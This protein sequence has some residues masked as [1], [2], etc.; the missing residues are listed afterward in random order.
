[1]NIT[2]KIKSLVDELITEFT[3]NHIAANDSLEQYVKEQR[4]NGVIFIAISSR[5]YIEDE[6]EIIVPQLYHS[7]EAGEKIRSLA[8]AIQS[9]FDIKCY[10]SE[11][12]P[13]LEGFFCKLINGIVAS[14]DSNRDAL[15]CNLLKKELESIKK[16]ILHVMVFCFPC[17]AM[18]LMENVKLSERIS[19]VLSSDDDL[20]E[21]RKKSYLHDRHHLNNAYLKVSL[22]DKMSQE[23]GASVA[24]NTS[25]FVANLINIDAHLMQLKVMPCVTSDARLK[26]AF[27][28][29][30]IVDSDG[31][32]RN[33]VTYNFPYD[34]ESCSQYWK[35][36]IE[37]AKSSQP[38]L[39]SDVVAEIL[40]LC[41]TAGKTRRV[42]DIII[43]AIN[44]YGDAYTEA[45]LESQIVKCT[46]AIES[47]V[48]YKKSDG[49][50][51][52]TIINR[53]C[54][55]RNAEVDSEIH[56]QI[57]SLYKARSEIVHGSRLKEVLTFCSLEFCRETIYSAI[58]VLSGFELGLS[59]EGY[60]K[61]LGV[62][63]DAL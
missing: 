39:E 33:S 48:N 38:H 8:E 14:K 17:K 19:I 18:G 42:V 34:L 46:T 7:R 60:A 43:N 4:A 11:L 20:N 47:L 28:F 23:L 35:R 5:N 29:Y 44:W 3:S 2:P 1:M 56:K 62:Y 27:D 31:E 45:N 37:H 30:R 55:I 26:N 53:V 12:H 51:T 58:S 13:Y 22:K 63:I 10:P 24:K 9:H 15:V 25:R 52:Q 21:V 59:G 36:I 6:S 40:R 41:V 54:K 49:Q 50:L 32:A 61:K 16:E 57:S